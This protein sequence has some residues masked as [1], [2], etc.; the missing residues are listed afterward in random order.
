MMDEACDP[1]VLGASPLVLGAR[2]GIL[3]PD[4][5]KESTDLRLWDR[6][7]HFQ[8]GLSGRCVSIVQIGGVDHAQRT[9][10]DVPVR[11]RRGSRLRFLALGM[12]ILCC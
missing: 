4:L 9:T 8:R 11:I 5:V 6:A 12:L 2:Q 7:A 3:H 10:M 1:L